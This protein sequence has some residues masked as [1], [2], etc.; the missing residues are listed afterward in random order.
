MDIE[1]TQNRLRGL[2]TAELNEVVFD[3]MLLQG[4]RR[5]LHPSKDAIVTA[6]LAARVE[7]IRRAKQARASKRA[8]TK[9]IPTIT[10]SVGGIVVHGFRTADGWDV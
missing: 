4:T 5:E 10:R 6:E 2:P 7:L 1:R 8:T 9:L 3:G